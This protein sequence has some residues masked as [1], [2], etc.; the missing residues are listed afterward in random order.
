MLKIFLNS[1]WKSIWNNGFLRALKLEKHLRNKIERATAR[2][3]FTAVS[4][5]MCL[6]FTDEFVLIDLR[7]EPVYREQL[8]RWDRHVVNFYEIIRLFMSPP[9]FSSILK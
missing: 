6:S 9:S 1:I 2:E 7:Y 3:V 5:S 4:R 8:Q